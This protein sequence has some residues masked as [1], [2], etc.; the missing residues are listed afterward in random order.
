MCSL[1]PWVSPFT[2]VRFKRSP[3]ASGSE[4]EPTP[5]E[6]VPEGHR[7]GDGPHVRPAGPPPPRPA[8]AA[9]VPDPADARLVYNHSVPPDLD[10]L[11]GSMRS[12]HVTRRFPA[13]MVIRW[14]QNRL[15][16]HQHGLIPATALLNAPSLKEPLSVST[17]PSRP[18]LSVMKWGTKSRST[19]LHLGSCKLMLTTG[20][21]EELFCSTRSLT[22]PLF[23]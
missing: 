12:V 5:T 20:A 6:P 4:E 16:R 8:G 3:N 11:P 23:T 22:R 19:F 2:W 15:I 13:P 17:T 14:V 18:G 21:G 1:Q 10:H 7:P 9:A